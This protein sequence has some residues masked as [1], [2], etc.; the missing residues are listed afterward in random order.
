MRALA[1][2]VA[3]TSP[4]AADERAV[5]YDTW[6]TPQQCA[7]STILPHG[8]KTAEPFEIRP[9]WLRHGQLWCRLTWFPAQSR[10]DGL[11][12]STHA[13]CGEDSVNGYRLDFAL[14]GDSL[15]LIWDQS[16]INKDLRRCNATS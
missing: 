4:V 12:V 14:S 15:T 2:V 11:F 1:L 10:K 9:G 13:R 7:R 8:T 5:L 3:L 16:L 6:G